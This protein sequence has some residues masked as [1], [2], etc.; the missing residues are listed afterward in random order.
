MKLV[1]TTAISVS[2]CGAFFGGAGNAYAASKEKSSPGGTLLLPLTPKLAGDNG[3]AMDSAP[4]TSA[5]DPKPELL[6]IAGY[7][8]P[9]TQQS[10]AKPAPAVQTPAPPAVDDG[11]APQSKAA[12]PAPKAQPVKAQ[13]PA[14]AA[15]PAKTQTAKAAPASGAPFAW[16][17]KSSD[18]KAAQAAQ[19]T[20]D[21]EAAAAAEQAA[22]SQTAQAPAESDA[23]SDSAAPTANSLV[24]ETATADDTA[25]KPTPGYVAA[26]NGT[27]EDMSTADLIDENTQLKGTVQI[28]ADDTEYD[29]D[30]N[31]FLGTGNAV[32]VI[33]GQ[34]SKL[35]ADS[36]LYDQNSQI[37]DAR[38]NVKILR[39]GQ[40]TTGSSFRFKVNS[41]EYL[42]TNPDTEVQGTTVIARQAIGKN[43]GLQFKK[44]TVTMPTPFR[45]HKNE[46]A[47]PL[48][49][50]E[51]T[52]EKDQNPEAY[53]PA[54]PS[55]KFTA[56]KMTYEK[57]KDEGNVTIQGGRLLMG[58]FSIPLPK[59][60]A[61]VGAQESRVVFPVT[62][63]FSNNINVGGMNVGPMF[64]HSVGKDGVFSWAP[65]VQ[66]GGKQIAG[67]D[68][69]NKGKIGAGFRLRYQT[70]RLNTQIA[71]GSA[72]NILVAELKYRFKNNVLF[73]SGI[74]R[75]MPDG[76][77]GI[78]RPRMIAEGVYN[79]TLSNV[80]FLA[81]V[82]FRS[83]AG[84]M[85]DQ[86]ALLGLTPQFGRLFTNDS[87]TKITSGYRVS[88]Q[89]MFTSHPLL[90]VG[91]D[92]YGAKLQ[93]FG[94]AAVRGYSS[95]DAMGMAQAGPILNANLG[96]VRLQT[97]YT[98]SGVRG[99]SP[100]VFDQFIQ[101]TKSCQLAGDWKVCK[102]LTL[103]GNF[104]YNLDSK[105]VL[106]RTVTAAI[107][108][109][110]FKV[111]LSRDTIRGI[112]R[113]GFDMLYGAPIP[114]DKLVLKAKP[115]QGQLGGI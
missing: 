6:P 45:L 57:Y 33:A 46:Y 87:S 22:A 39:D 71:Y 72:S 76:L 79:K 65:L 2:L 19:K 96:R 30:R 27:A 103:G 98:Q 43:G 48:S 75:Y 105:M 40:L 95:G 106:G 38:G 37:I 12:A 90:A 70:R 20:K 26:E 1:V 24:E 82:D 41:D 34:N 29:Q 61:T 83:S 89:M 59:F 100:F 17:T 64:N 25:L 85:Q 67:G 51:E 28:V 73:Q 42:I 4:A 55:Y 88:Q 56:R 32:A 78:R 80:P 7:L 35:E 14:K 94:G 108:P 109:D 77:F 74:N 63:F 112:N 62:P 58:N 60:V 8:K 111:I 31:T 52:R 113:F 93:L 66:F 69:P 15:T 18:A 99:Q 81:M 10:A 50:M 97:G 92:R 16:P 11:P 115:D 54:K 23:Q 102:W 110:D 21:D 5:R 49:A 44:G 84:W 91:D 36:I 104:M 107:G 68:D 53:L 13:A 114:Y 3:S 9:S 86:P 47:G 101:G